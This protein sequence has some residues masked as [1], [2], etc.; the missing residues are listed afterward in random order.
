MELISKTRILNNS[1]E[2]KYVVQY[3][4]GFWDIWRGD[5]EYQYFDNIGSN[6]WS[7]PKQED[8]LQECRA[9][10]ISLLASGVVE[11]YP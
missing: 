8:A 5:F 11:E 10:C 7:Y 1:I 4:T 3:K 2:C 6:V 9:R